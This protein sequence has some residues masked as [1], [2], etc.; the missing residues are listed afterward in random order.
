[1]AARHSGPGLAQGP[2]GEDDVDAL[3]D[4]MFEMEEELEEGIPPQEEMEV[5]VG[6]AGRS[7]ARP[8][9]PGLDPSN[10]PLSEL[11]LHRR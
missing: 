11:W 8:A 4:E 7:W 10:N 6:E 3:V 2:A 9:P 5:D 1:M